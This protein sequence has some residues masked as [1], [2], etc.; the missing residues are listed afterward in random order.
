MDTDTGTI[1]LD[2]ASRLFADAA[3]L[4]S[5]VLAKDDAWRDRLWAGIEEIG[6]NVAAVPEGLGGA[7]A[8]L[9]ASL[10]VLRAAGNAA[11]SVPLA[12]T[13]LAGWM[14]GA[15]GIAA[16]EGKLA[17]GP[18]GFDDRLRLDGDGRLSGRVARLPFARDCARAALLVGQ[19]QR[20]AQGEGLAV[21]LVD[22]ADAAIA[23]RENLAREPS[24]MVDFD[25]VEPLAV[26]PAPAA[27][28]A[29]TT[30]LMGAA[31]R[32]MQIAGALEEMLRIT[33]DYVQQR[34]AF[35][36]TLSKFQVVQHGL[37]QLA[38]DV[39]VSLSA[40]AS[41]IETLDTL[42]AEGRSLE[43]AELRLEVMSA[44]IRTAEAA[45]NGARIAHQLH[46]AIGVTDE[47][48]LHRLTLRALSWRDDY[49]NDTQWAGRLGAMLG[50]L[51]GD[52]LWA[53]LSKR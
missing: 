40:A 31:A 13:I 39:S 35:G 6:L 20:Q 2:A 43:D 34:P 37:A 14:L 25:K 42:L 36:R 52:G 47:H 33:T 12:E 51:D 16:Q 23:P 48:V 32:A 11:L 30:L 9:G 15:A 53:L 41:A 21:V 44:K 10:G 46:G 7:D 8:G 18:S 26:A 29:E 38:S 28:T 50:R 1:I 49:G 27:F 3:D 5:V 45:G 19:G 17:F 24:D 22:L 4:Q